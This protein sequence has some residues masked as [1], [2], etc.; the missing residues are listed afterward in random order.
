MP[1][2]AMTS[3]PGVFCLS[4][5][6]PLDREDH[7]DGHPIEVATRYRVGDADRSVR[8]GGEHS[9]QPDANALVSRRNL[10]RHTDHPTSRRASVIWTGDMG[11]LTCG[12]DEP[13]VLHGHHSVAA[14]V[15]ADHGHRPEHDHAV[16]PAASP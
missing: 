16:K 4:P 2:T 11:L 3:G 8:K 10:E 14:H 15:A 7:H 1:S 9:G 12:R 6:S 5:V 13:P